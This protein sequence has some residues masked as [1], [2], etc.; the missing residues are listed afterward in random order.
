MWTGGITLGYLQCCRHQFYP[1][2]QMLPDLMLIS[3]N[4]DEVFRGKVENGLYIVES[5]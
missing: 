4:C 2:K 5:K 1:F 3:E